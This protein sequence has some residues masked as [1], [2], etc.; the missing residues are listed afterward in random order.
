MLIMKKDALTKIKDKNAP[1]VLFFMSDFLKDY[2]RDASM[3]KDVLSWVR[4][5]QIKRFSYGLYYFKGKNEP[6]A[7]DAIR[8]RYVERSGKRYGFFG[9]SAFVQEVKGL[10]IRLN[11]KVIEVVSNVATSGK[12]TVREFGKTFI[13]KKPYMKI[14][15]YN[16][17]MVSFL[18]Y[19]TNTPLP[20]IE[21]NLSA[22]SNFVRQEHLSALTMA[23]IISLFP[24]KTF[25]KLLKT[26]L[27]R[28]F[29]KH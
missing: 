18:T 21:Q 11:D 27:Y 2:M 5:G 17:S 13:L 7:L 20:D 15:K 28:S 8:I 4:N 16:V 12:K 26:D 9:G 3:K 19:I 6:T 1:G 10:P 23:D 25:S 14:D 22:L 29:W 24:S